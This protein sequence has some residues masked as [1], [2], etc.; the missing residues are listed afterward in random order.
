MLL[1]RINNSC[2][3]AGKPKIKCEV[4]KWTLMRLFIV[5]SS[6]RPDIN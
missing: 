4:F 2:G 6:Y 3:M 5:F 1:T